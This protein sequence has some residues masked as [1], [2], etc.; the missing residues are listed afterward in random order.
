MS[1]LVGCCVC[2]CVCAL[3]CHPNIT[4]R[5]IAGTRLST[6]VIAVSGLNRDVVQGLGYEPGFALVGYGRLGLCCASSES[7][8]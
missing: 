4:D 3:A 6:H 1:L 8:W 2:V 7:L 5:R